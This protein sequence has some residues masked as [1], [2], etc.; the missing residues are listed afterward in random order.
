MDHDLFS[1]LNFFLFFLHIRLLGGVELMQALGLRLEENGT[2]LALR[3]DG[4]AA[5]VKWDRVPESVLRRLDA[6]AKV[7]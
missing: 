1:R 2:V 6:A 4:H 7:R 5:G 3:E